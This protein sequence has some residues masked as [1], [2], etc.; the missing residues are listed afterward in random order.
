MIQEYSLSISTEKKIKTYYSGVF[1]L[2][3]KAI[4]II[5]AYDKDQ[6]RQILMDSL[7]LKG[8]Q[9]SEKEL[10]KIEPIEFIPGVALL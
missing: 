10:D 1:D 9:P 8:Y 3:N 5:W 2:P 4:L 7:K 6:A